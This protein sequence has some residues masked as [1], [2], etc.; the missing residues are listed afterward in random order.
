MTI[1]ERISQL[2]G[3]L[4]IEFLD[5]LDKIYIQGQIQ[6]LKWVEAE[7][8]REIKELGELLKEMAENR[9]GDKTNH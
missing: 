2:K 5:T 4:E 1:K 6:A 8:K 9:R 7:R 3:R